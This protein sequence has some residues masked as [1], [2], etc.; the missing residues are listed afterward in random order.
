MRAGNN[1]THAAQATDVS[2][3]LA[4]VGRFYATAWLKAYAT[5]FPGSGMLKLRNGGLN[6]GV[7]RDIEELARG[8]LHGLPGQAIPANRARCEARP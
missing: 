7:D 5:K 6:G 1:G 8:A 3:V 2:V 4:K